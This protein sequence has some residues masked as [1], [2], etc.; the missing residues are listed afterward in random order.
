MTHARE[1]LAWLIWCFDQG[2]VNPRDRAI[3]TN[4]LLDDP[5]RLNPHDAKLR[6]QL[7]AMADEILALLYHRCHCGTGHLA[8]ADDTKDSEGYVHDEGGK[9]YMQT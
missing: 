7:L 1:H 4:W 8:K 5:A 9:P 2:Y 3:L 6:L